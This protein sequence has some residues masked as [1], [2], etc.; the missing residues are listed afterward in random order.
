MLVW[1]NPNRSSWT[2]NFLECSV[3]FCC[4]GTVKQNCLINAYDGLTNKYVEQNSRDYSAGD[5]HEINRIQNVIPTKSAAQQKM[6]NR[7]LRNLPIAAAP[8]SIRSMVKNESVKNELYKEWWN[9][10]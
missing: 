3:I 4:L 1:S 7:V 10:K 2:E 5:S 9:S 6:Q 8:N